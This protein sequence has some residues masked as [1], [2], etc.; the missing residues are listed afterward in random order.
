MVWRDPGLKWTES[1]DSKWT[2]FHSLLL[3]N[4]SPP[5]LIT[6]NSKN[7]VIIP[8]GFFWQELRRIAWLSSSG[9]RS[10]K[11][12]WSN[13]GWGWISKGLEW[14]G[15][16]Q[17]CLRGDMWSFCVGWFWL[18][19]HSM[20]AQD[21]QSVQMAADSFRRQRSSWQAEMALPLLS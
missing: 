1:G 8:P 5:N 20:A 4:K 18:L 9:S 16:G 14:R 19:I 21:T 11:E 10:P 13:G 7:H 12:L 15:A 17:A 6:K 3:H 2:L